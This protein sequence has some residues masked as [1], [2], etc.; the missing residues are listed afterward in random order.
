MKNEEANS[1]T[2]SRENE[3][4]PLSGKKPYHRKKSDK[5]T[6]PKKYILI[7]VFILISIFILFL[8]SCLILFSKK[9]DTKNLKGIENEDYR[10]SIYTN[11]RKKK[12]GGNKLEEID[13]NDEDNEEG[14]NKPFKKRKSKEGK[15]FDDDDNDENDDNKDEPILIKNHTEKIKIEETEKHKETENVKIQEKNDVNNI[16]IN[17]K[18]N[19]KKDVFDEEDNNE[20]DGKKKN[21]NAKV[22]DEKE[23]A[24]NEQQEPVLQQKE[25]LKQKKEENEDNE[26]IKHDKPEE[27]NKNN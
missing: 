16:Q 24:N 7:L 4:V 22:F 18:K 27:D 14:V 13:V 17:P 6:F 1:I 15:L 11:E 12:F 19:Q 2:S 21:K 23:D 26:F 20:G 3:N 5:K 8:I 9:K 10:L 25:I